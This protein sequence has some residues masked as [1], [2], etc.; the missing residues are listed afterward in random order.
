METK[1]VGINGSPHVNGPCSTALRLTLDHAWKAGAK[2][3]FVHLAEFIGKPFDGNFDTPLASLQFLLDLIKRADGLIFAT[4][5]HWFNVSSL[6][7]TLID[8]MSRLESPDFP[9]EGKVA[10]FIA[11]CEEDGGM[12]ACLQM[13]APL[14]HM[15]CIIPPYGMVF[16]N[17]SIPTGGENGWQD[18]DFAL[19]GSNIV[20]LIEATTSY[21]STWSSWGYYN[22][23]K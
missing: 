20:R 17:T 1:I 21:P 18:R 10:G 14:I 8:E 13:A 4:P 22:T 19:L 12:Q 11:T 7:K 15:G 6:M 5:V 9:L 3:D 23:T 16:K 2:T